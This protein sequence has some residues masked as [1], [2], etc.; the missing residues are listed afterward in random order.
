MRITLL[1]WCLES[2]EYSQFSPFKHEPWTKNLQSILENDKK[3]ESLMFLQS[4]SIKA[5]KRVKSL[6]SIGQWKSQSLFKTRHWNKL[7]LPFGHLGIVRGKKGIQTKEKNLKG[8]GEAFFL[9]FR[10]DFSDDFSTVFED[11]ARFITLHHL[12]SLHFRLL[13]FFL[14]NYPLSFLI[15]LLNKTKPTICS[16]WWNM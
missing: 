12:S 14:L 6:L 3:I 7:D 11:R 13:L 10:G 1:A 2:W 5:I 16:L 15:K 8:K 4:S 9:Y